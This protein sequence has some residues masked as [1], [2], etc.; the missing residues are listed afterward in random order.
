MSKVTLYICD[1]CKTDGYLKKA[2]ASYN[3]DDSKE[4]HVCKKHL[5][6]VKQAGFEIHYL[7][8]SLEVSCL[9]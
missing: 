9:K 2:V 7:S 3:G 4:F 6:D 8:Q 5:K 1:F